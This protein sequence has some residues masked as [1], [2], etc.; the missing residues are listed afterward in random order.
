MTA[1]RRVSAIQISG[2]K[3]LIT[4]SVLTPPTGFPFLGTKRA[5]MRAAIGHRV[6]RAD[7]QARARRPER[8][9]VGTDLGPRGKSSV[10]ALVVGFT[11][12]F[13]SGR[14]RFVNAGVT[15]QTAELFLFVPFSALLRSQRHKRKPVHFL[16]GLFVSSFFLLFRFKQCLR[17]KP[18][19]ADRCALLT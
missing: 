15:T 10:V 13:N 6:C 11:N 9:H 14:G 2:A 7:C 4:R 5:T 1:T 17:T 12:R 8:E 19:S 16:G 18:Q 3:V